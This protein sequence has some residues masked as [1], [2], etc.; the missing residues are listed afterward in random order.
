[1]VR[2]TTLLQ[3]ERR[4]DA[5][6]FLWTPATLLVLSTVLAILVLMGVVCIRLGRMTR[7][8]PS[9]ERPRA[10]LFD[11]FVRAPTGPP[12]REREVVGAG[13]E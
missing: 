4:R 6:M 11:R 9:V 7:Q 13:R 2:D 8:P 12:P 10:L 3:I 5:P 1:M